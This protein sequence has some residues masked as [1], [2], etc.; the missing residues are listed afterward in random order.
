ME[1]SYFYISRIQIWK[2]C[3]L[4]MKQIEKLHLASKEFVSIKTIPQSQ[5]SFHEQIN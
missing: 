4:V 2:G 1:Q 3:T 5:F